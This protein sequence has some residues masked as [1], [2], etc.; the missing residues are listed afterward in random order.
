VHDPVFIMML[1]A[2]RHFQV[3]AILSALDRAEA[4]ATTKAFK[5]A[6]RVAARVL[7]RLRVAGRTAS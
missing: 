1:R 3:V 5:E 2:R 7:A 4:Q 6:A